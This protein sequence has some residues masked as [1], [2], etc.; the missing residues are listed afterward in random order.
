[1]DVDSICRAG[2]VEAPAHDRLRDQAGLPEGAGE[3]H[4][5]QFRADLPCA[6]ETRKRKTGA[7]GSAAGPP[8]PYSLFY[9]RQGGRGFAELAV[10]PERSGKPPGADASAI[11]RGPCGA[12]GAKRLRPGVPQSGRSPAGPLRR[13][14]QVAERYPLQQSAAADL[15]A[16]HGVRG[17]AKRVPPALGRRGAGVYDKSKQEE[18]TMTSTSAHQKFSGLLM[19]IGSLVF[20][21]AGAFWSDRNGW[22]RMATTTMTL[23]ATAWAVTFVFDGF[24]APNIVRRL[25][26]ETGW[27]ALSVNQDV[28]IRM[29]LVSWLMLGFSMIAG[30]I[31]TLVSRST[32]GANMLAW[33][34]ILLGVWPIIAWV[35]GAFLPGPFTSRYWNATAVST[36][37][38]F[39]AAGIFL[40]LSA[41][42]QDG[43]SELAGASR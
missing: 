43:R 30:G 24:V 27:Y 38:W 40:M 33:A 10:L 28:V 2:D 18:K 3:F 35:T 41:E 13:H 21:Y 29:G 9:Y 5:H 15:E 39:L 1:M 12:G 25:T 36:A 8:G 17:F 37:I 14:T 22:T 20:V 23:A 16:G 7:P 4:A 19:V 6:R 42:P 26:P 11:F 32:R 34:G 31:G